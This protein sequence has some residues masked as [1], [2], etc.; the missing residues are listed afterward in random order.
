MTI[1]ICCG[2]VN[3]ASSS[4][5]YPHC[6]GNS[7]REVK[8]K[9]NAIVGEIKNLEC[10]STDPAAG[11]CFSNDKHNVGWEVERPLAIWEKWEISPVSRGSRG[12]RGDTHL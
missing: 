8:D 7:H 1:G 6:G 11:V 5:V 10:L 12:G 2:S 4:G 9:A 3:A